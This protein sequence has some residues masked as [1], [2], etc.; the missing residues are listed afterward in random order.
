MAYNLIL[1][2]GNIYR[3]EYSNKEI[4]FRMKSLKSNGNYLELD[5]DSFYD[6]ENFKMDSIYSL[7]GLGALAVSKIKNLNVWK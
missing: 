1:Q 6:C 7:N 2:K 5:G 4:I 3:C